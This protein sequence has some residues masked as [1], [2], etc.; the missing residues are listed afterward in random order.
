M[1]QRSTIIPPNTVRI[2]NNGTCFFALTRTEILSRIKW[3]S[4]LGAIECNDSLDDYLLLL[5]FFS[6]PYDDDLFKTAT[7][8]KEAG[9]FN[10]LPKS[11]FL[12]SLS[13]FFFFF[14]G[15]SE[16][17]KLAPLMCALCRYLRS[18]VILH[19][20]LFKGWHHRRIRDV[21]QWWSSPKD[22][23]F[24]IMLNDLLR[25]KVSFGRMILH[26]R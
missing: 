8:N 18:T 1:W 6:L 25:R 5:L 4:L 19:F 20:F 24:V 12:F 14:E 16:T 15:E 17:C 9:Q 7:P 3:T 2:P 10:F 21:F 22:V 13:P 26:F 11:Y 23:M